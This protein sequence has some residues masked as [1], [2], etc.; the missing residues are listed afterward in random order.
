MHCF[1][2]LLKRCDAVQVSTEALQFCLQELAQR[3]EVFPNQLVDLSSPRFDAD[4]FIATP[5]SPLVLGWGGSSGHL[6][7]LH[8]IS[9]PLI[10]FLN[11]HDNVRF[12]LMGDPQ[13]AVPFSS[14][15]AH[16]FCFYPA[17][18]LVNY[19][20]LLDHLHKCIA[21]LLPTEYYCCL[22]DVK[23]LE[24]ASHSVFPLLQDLDTF[25]YLIDTESAFLFSNNSEFIYKLTSFFVALSLVNCCF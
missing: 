21:P 15:P 1:E 24:Y 16:K 19:L 17:G 23:F 11:Q 13:F 10:K 9:A 8:S 3:I 25:D 14:L 4:E 20:S 12:E 7:D 18:S 6:E 22:S 5:D 2:Q